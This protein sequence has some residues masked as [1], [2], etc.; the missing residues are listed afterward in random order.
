MEII[1][2]GVASFLTWLV[3]KRAVISGDLSD[4]IF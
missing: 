1:I 3:K 2:P 4:E